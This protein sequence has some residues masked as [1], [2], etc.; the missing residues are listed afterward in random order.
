M[1]G[2]STGEVPARSEATETTG[3]GRPEDIEQALNQKYA[4]LLPLEPT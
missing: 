3:S 2:L 4:N 1:F